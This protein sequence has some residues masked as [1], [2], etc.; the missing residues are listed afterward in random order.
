MGATGDGRDAQAGAHGVA[1]TGGSQKTRGWRWLDCQALVVTGDADAADVASS[2]EARYTLGCAAGG[3]GGK[4]VL[5]WWDV[6]AKLLCV[7]VATTGGA[8]RVGGGCSQRR[9]LRGGSSDDEN[10]SS[11]SWSTETADRGDVLWVATRASLQSDGV[12]RSRGG[13]WRLAIEVLH[14]GGLLARR[15][16]C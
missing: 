7:E 1:W 10:G 8:Q 12:V 9:R 11:G 2:S 5:A 16:A 14:S 6:R 3:T 13:R 15:F 4:D